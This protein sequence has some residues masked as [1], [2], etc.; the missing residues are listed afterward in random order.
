VPIKSPHTDPLESPNPVPII[1]G[2]KTNDMVLDLDLASDL[3]GFLDEF[4]NADLNDCVDFIC[5]KHDIDATDELIDEIADFF[6]A[7]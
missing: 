1:R 2:H 5:E 7:N 6:F 4:Q 3:F